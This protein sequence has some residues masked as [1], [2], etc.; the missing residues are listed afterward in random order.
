MKTF[1]ADAIASIEKYVIRYL[2]D[3]RVD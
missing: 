2:R 1:V 3:G